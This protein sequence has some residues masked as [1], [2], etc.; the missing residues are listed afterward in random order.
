MEKQLPTARLAAEQTITRQVYISGIRGPHSLYLGV[1]YFYRGHQL[2]AYP[3]CNPIEPVPFSTSKGIVIVGTAPAFAPA[4][5]PDAPDLVSEQSL[6]VLER[7]CRVVWGEQREREEAQVREINEGI[8]ERMEEE[9]GK[10]RLGSKAVVAAPAEKRAC[11]VLVPTQVASRMRS[12]GGPQSSLPTLAVHEASAVLGSS[13]SG[14][15]HSSLQSNVVALNAVSEVLNLQQYLDHATPHRPTPHMGFNTSLANLGAQHARGYGEPSS[16]A[17]PTLFHPSS[18]AGSFASLSALNMPGH[19]RSTPPINTGQTSNIP[20]YAPSAYYQEEIYTPHDRA[21]FLADSAP[22]SRLNSVS[23]TPYPSRPVSPT[24]SVHHTRGSSLRQ[25][26]STSRLTSMLT[27]DRVPRVVSP[28]P[29][30]LEGTTHFTGLNPDSDTNSC[31]EDPTSPPYSR[32][33]PIGTGRPRRASMA[34]NQAYNAANES[35]S[36]RQPVC[37]VH[38]EGCDGVTVTETWKTQHAKETYGFRDLYPIIHGAGDRIMVDWAILL[39]AER[40][41]MRL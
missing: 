15:L 16:T 7:S 37:V 6:A 39:E 31:L 4:Y 22:G 29:D 24:Q 33:K 17:G 32:N 26:S 20:T 11:A 38:G 9:E 14:L 3:A 28:L 35:V 13:S 25:I 8:K 5:D 36:V 1:A 19:E 23:N 21:R 18:R 40:G 10:L 12:R 34:L 27:E 30:V 2:Y 41:Q